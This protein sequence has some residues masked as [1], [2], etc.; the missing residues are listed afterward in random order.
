MRE[1]Y[2]WKLDNINEELNR[3]EI[4]LINY[5]RTS[6]ESSNNEEFLLKY[7]TTPEET[8]HI[9]TSNRTYQL[10]EI[11]RE[12]MIK[13]KCKIADLAKSIDMNEKT[14][15][16]ILNGENRVHNIDTILKICVS[17][18]C[19]KDEAFKIVKLS[20]YN[21]NMDGLERVRLIIFVLENQDFNKINIDNLLHANDQKVLFSKK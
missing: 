19:T 20:G 11:I 1:D 12:L 5:F 6:N 2:L 13:K 16:R 9:F 15:S 7:N 4:D 8:K 10:G 14:I 21:P 18:K 3:I 17:L